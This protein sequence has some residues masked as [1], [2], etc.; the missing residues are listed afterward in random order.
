M[1]KSPIEWTDYTWNPV[2][3][4]T[5]STHKD[6]GCHCRSC[7]D[8]GSD[9]G[10]SKASKETKKYHVKYNRFSDKYG[11][12]L[13]REKNIFRRMHGPGDTLVYNS[14]HYRILRVALSKK[15]TTY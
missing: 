1:N 8:K 5:H 10:M 2:T 15:H 12:L 9:E 7:G 11:N 3:G 6:V 14:I 4:S 13:W